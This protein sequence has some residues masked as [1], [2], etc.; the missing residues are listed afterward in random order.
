MSAAAISPKVLIV[1]DQP[2]NLDALEAML[3]SLECVLIRAE[4]A[5]AALLRLLKHDFA[6]IVLDIQMPDMN[7]IELAKLIKQR[8]R[9]HDVPLLFL[10][11]HLVEER[12]V[13]QGYG[14]GAVDYLSKPINPDILRSKVA[15]FLDLFKKTRALAELNQ[16]LERQ[17]ADRVAAEMALQ[18]ANEQLERRVRERTA[19]LRAAHEGVQ[20]NEQRLLMAMH[21]GQIAAWEWNLQTNEVTWS[22]EPEPL[23]GFPVGALGPEKRIWKALHPDDRQAVEDALSSAVR[24][25]LYEAEYRVVRPDGSNKWIRERGRLIRSE[26]GADRL[27]GVS[28]DRTAEQAAASEREQLLKAAREARDEAER[29]SRLKD[30]FL[31]TL[32]HE[33]R[34]PMNAIL[35]WLSILDQGK[36]IRDVYSALTV[37]R[38]NAE[39]QAKLI[40]DLLDMNRLISGNVRIDVGLV[41]VAALSQSTI[42]ALQPAADAKGVQLIA[43]VDAGIGPVSADARRLQQVLWNVMHNAIKFTP[44]GGRVEIYAKKT[45]TSLHIA[46]Q[47][48]G[49][50]ISPQFLPHVFERFRQEDASHVREKF[51]LGLGLSIAR[52]LVELHGGS[53]RA[54]SRGSGHGARFEID[55]P[56]APASSTHRPSDPL[57]VV[58]SSAASI[59]RIAT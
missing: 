17:V 15:V 2:R 27:V 56:V 46:V 1:D 20:E 26:A 53:I 8:K 59:A 23:F 57:P 16:A 34:T 5:D 36:P 58:Q 31:A 21:V 3:S 10:T 49:Q 24:S 42:Q 14:V 7:G 54:F 43:S 45:E 40:D 32:S 11:A 47:D 19:A 37:I 6:A 52:H 48:N 50:G 12:D 41:E 13:L 38:R 39:L 33:L 51:G 44:A 28:R 18:V 4:S 9:S 22:T 30:E 29:Q 25:G 35:G 55:L